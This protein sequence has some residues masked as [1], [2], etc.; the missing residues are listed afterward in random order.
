MGKYLI[1]TAPG[2]KKRKK[3]FWKFLHEKVEIGIAKIF[4]IKLNAT[5]LFF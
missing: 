5:I 1:F 2:E 3:T 4:K